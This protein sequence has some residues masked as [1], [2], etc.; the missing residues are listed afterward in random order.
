[1]QGLGDERSEDPEAGISSGDDRHLD[2]VRKHVLRLPSS[3]VKPVSVKRLSGKRLWMKR[4]SLGPVPVATV[5][6]L[7]DD[8]VGSRSLIKKQWITGKHDKVQEKI[9]GRKSKELDKLLDLHAAGGR[10]RTEV[11]PAMSS[12]GASSRT[13]STSRLDDVVAF[14]LLPGDA[15][16]GFI[17]TPDAATGQENELGNAPLMCEQAKDSLTGKQGDAAPRSMM[18]K[19]G[20]GSKP[21]KHQFGQGMA[22]HTTPPSSTDAQARAYHTSTPFRQQEAATAEMPQPP[23]DL[24]AMSPKKLET[25]NG[26]RAQLR[27]WQELH[28]DED[29]L[30]DNVDLGNDADTGEL[31]NNLTRLPDEKTAFANTQAENEEDEREAMAHFTQ[32]PSDEP[33]SSDMG[34]KFLKTGDLVEI[35]FVKSERES[36][37]AV[38]VR[39]TGTLAQFYTMQGRWLHVMEKKVMYS[40]P[41]WVSEDTI[42]PILQ[43][44]PSPDEVEND[45]EGLMDESYIKDMSVPRHVAAPL[46]SRMVQFHAEAQEIY[47]RNASTLDNAHQLLAHET[48][49]RY[50]SLVSAATTLLKTPADQLPVTALF[51]VRQALSHAGFAFNIDRR[52]HRL[53][54]YLQIRSKEQ[55]KMVEQVRRWLREWQDDLAVTA[56]MDEQQAR[57]HRATRGA[58]YVYGFLSKAKKIIARSREDRQPTP[59]GQVGPSKVRLPITQEKDCVKV[60]KS[61][62]F[63]E[64]DTELVR[65]LEAWSLSN[66]FLGLPRVESLPP[67]LLQATGL[68]NEYTLNTAT[69]L[70]FL[71]ELGTIMPYEN[72]VR[73]DQHLLLPSSQH[74]RPLQNLMTSL[75]DMADKHNFVD[76]MADLRHDWGR[77]PVYCIDDASAH[78]ID[79][80]LSIEPAAVA[81]DGVKEWW[82][83]IHIANPT[84]FFNRDHPLAKMARHMGES[85]YMP[86]RTYMMLPRWATQRHFSLARDRPCLTF[87]AR[88]DAEGRTLERK[89]RPGTI[90]NVLRLTPSEVGDL[91]GVSGQNQRPEMVLTVGGEPPPPKKRKSYVGEVNPEMVQELQTLRML[92][93]KRADIRKA[94]GGLFFDV[95]KPE[96]NVWQSHKAPGLAWDHPHRRGSRHVEGDPVIQ[97]KT[98]GLVN[99]FSA[100]SD[101]PNVMVRECMLLA[102]EVAAAW[103]DER[104]IPAVFRGSVP[105]PGKLS[106]DQ[107]FEEHLAPLVAQRTTG[108]KVGDYPMHLGMQYLETFGTTSLSTRPFK[109][110]I[111]GMQNYGKVTSP[112]RRY[113]DMIFHWQIEAALRE[114]AT[115][116]KSL[117]TS[118]P[119]ADRRFLPFSTPVLNTILIGLQPR[120]SIIMKAKMFAENFWINLLLFRAH[121]YHETPLPLGNDN[122]T[123]HAY[124]H[125]DPK[126]GFH[127]QSVIVK[128]LNVVA[129]L[130]NPEDCGVHGQIRQGDVWECEVDNVDCFRRVPFLRPRNLVERAE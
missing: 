43:Y 4:L 65:F 22:W 45:L 20:L 70:L 103:C 124:V 1:M 19:S 93:E 86:E 91:L 29:L 92:A 82:V 10:Q 2:L 40:I 24:M 78:E 101:T 98:K 59:Y 72:R 128:E 64:Q 105:R 107:F 123:V 25:P 121:H 100:S 37:V 94:A 95:H 26:I 62:E 60:T 87:S 130:M 104:A 83:H 32:A 115:T 108:G 99:W 118:N 88:M 76:S 15:D 110:K 52:S 67:L 47:R 71:Q 117:I 39:R 97:M 73:F 80:G 27:K 21:S 85:I 28:G 109:H 58:S 35:E 34:S 89:I 126:S 119:D 44:L 120:E 14:K 55:V 23:P 49:L 63:A 5:E 11:L 102:C 66:M 125:V 31:S 53:T 69:G 38:F 16:A 54:G 96:I 129:S 106:S 6:P 112:L 68:Y 81:S 42:K 111:L 50:G 30:H 127:T 113:G 51:A 116:G 12:A 48:D 114:E 18:P 8:V 46:V 61:D 3:N 36:L 56:T 13:P 77:L 57:R 90:K 79:D 17:D 41:G 7:S 9:E 122:K 33:S 75:I 74:S 84:A